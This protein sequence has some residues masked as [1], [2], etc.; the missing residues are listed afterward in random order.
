MH[1]SDLALWRYSVIAP[2]LHLAPDTS[3]ASLAR[4]LASEPKLGPAGEP[5]SLSAETILRWFRSYRVTGLPGLEKSLRKDRGQCRALSPADLKEILAIADDRPHLTIRLIHKEAETRLSRPLSLKATYRVLAGHRR[6]RER[7]EKEGEK[8]PPRRRDVGV[9][10][11][12][13]LADTMH[14][15]RV[16]GPRRTTRK[17]YLIAFMDD[18][19]RAVMAARFTTADDVAGL[20]PIFREAILARGCPSR[21]LCDN[22]PSYRSRVLATACA[23]LGIHLVHAS[24]YRPT[25]KARLERFFLT[26]RLGFEPTLP[27][28]PIS[29][30]DLNEAW[31]KFLFAYHARPHSSL[32]EIASRPTTPLSYY[33]AHLPGGIRYV[34]ELS[35]D[36]LLVVEETRRVGRD[37]TIRV[38]GNVFEVDP[39]LAGDRVVARFNPAAPAFVIYRPLS[40]PEAPFVRA[41]PVQ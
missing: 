32:S 27:K 6:Q 39:A 34:S 24:P 3:L 41:F 13:W 9:P 31:A 36:E 18:A 35:L 16:A 20:I 17:S 30:A 28:Q 37:A 38:A 23:G 7:A 10:Q 22:G 21:L 4:T 1:A 19:S 8:K 15:P 14:G 26:V 33:L 25:S 29:L 11:T 2:L 5:V 40:K 12:L